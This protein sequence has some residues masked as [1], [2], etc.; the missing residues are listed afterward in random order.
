M[1]TRF[2]L[3]AELTIFSAA[4]TQAALLGWLA[5]Q[6][7]EPAEPLALEAQQLLDLD[8]AGVQLLCAFSALVA[9]KGW[10]WQLVSPTETLVNACRTLGLAS[11]LDSHTASEP[12]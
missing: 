2:E 12:S 10:A 1:T 11:W 4:E 6:P 7:G 3:P 5:S 8:G 9:H